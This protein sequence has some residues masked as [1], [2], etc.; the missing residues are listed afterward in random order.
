[1]GPTRGRDRASAAH[2]CIL[3]A[4]YGDGDGETYIVPLMVASGPAA[5]AI[6][7][8]HPNATVAWLERKGA[9]PQLLYDA[10]V[11]TRFAAATLD[12]FRRR[13]TFASPSGGELR[14][15]TSPELRRVLDPD[16]DLT[17]YIPAVEQS[18]T[19]VVFGSKL[20]MKMF[21][22]AQEGVNPDLEMGEYLTDV[23]GYEHTAALFGAAEYSKGKGEPRTIG[24]LNAF[25]VN[26][27]DTW[28]YSLDA[29]SLY[30]EQ[31]IAEIPD[32]DAVVPGWGDVL[33]LV[34]T[35]PPPLVR[36]AIGPYFD[37][38]RL[39]GERTAEMHLA[40]ASGTSDAFRPEPFTTLYQRSLLQS[41][42]AQL[43]PTLTMLRRALSTLDDN[44]QRDGQTVLDGEAFLLDAFSAL[45]SHRIDTHRIRV[46][47]DFHLGQVL[48]AGRDFVIIDFEGE[49]SRA[50]TER[51]IKK[52]GLADVAGMLRSFQYAAR[53][54]LL[55]HA[56]RGLVTTEHLPAFERREQLWQ[57]WITIGYLTGY[58]SVTEGTPI[59]PDDPADL[60]T[61]LSAYTL[62][63][64]LYEVRYDLAHRPDWAPIPLHGIVQLL[65]S[66][67]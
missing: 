27:G 17:P 58:L 34:D 45:T 14:L 39:L 4:E 31:A 63:K 60:L 52:T 19:S 35:E 48:H 2:L 40:L 50:P 30:Y 65:A 56:D 53:A 9:E 23:A 44:G 62:D 66:A 16:D 42:R 12:A 54:G 37:S 26:E 55:A 8:D 21:R 7:A 1:M 38:I 22:R 5:E 59:V 51:R 11:D 18:N 47:G 43:R 24:L 36:D 28:R 33:G 41:M 20:V 64:A 10:L 49:P 3:H 61:L 15:R 13:K 6:L 32:H 25:V 57:M 46:H 29:L 67:S